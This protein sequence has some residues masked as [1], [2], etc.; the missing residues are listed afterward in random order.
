MSVAKDLIAQAAA[1]RS[2]WKLACRVVSTSNLTLSGLQAVDGVALAEDDRV[3][4]AGQTAG[5]LNGVYMVKPGAWVRAPEM[6]TSERVQLGSTMLVLEGSY[7]FTTWRLTSPTSGTVRLGVTAL[8]FEQARDDGE[9]LD[10]D[11][12]TAP[13]VH[14]GATGVYTTSSLSFN[15]SIDPSVALVADLV[16]DNGIVAASED[17]LPLCVLIHGYHQSGASIVASVRQRFASYGFA[18]LVIALRADK[19]DG[20]REVHDVDDAIAEAVAEHPT[21]AYAPDGSV[22]LEVGYSGGGGT[23]M[24]R[25][26]KRPDAANIRVAFFG[27]SDYGYDTTDSLWALRA[28]FQDELEVAVGDRT[29]V[30]YPYR[31][32]NAVEAIGKALMLAPV[33]K[34][35]APRLYLFWD[36]ADNSIP[37]S[38]RVRDAIVARGAENRLSYYQST[39]E[40]DVR[41]EHGYPDTVPDLIFAE[42][43]FVR[44][45]LTYDYWTV[46]PVGTCRVLGWMKTKRFEI[47]CGPNADPKNDEETGGK[48][49]VV[50]LEYDTT[51]GQ[52]IVTPRSGPKEE[53]G[54]FTPFFAS[55]THDSETA[56]KEIS[57]S[58]EWEF[59]DNVTVAELTK[60]SDLAGCTCELDSRVGITLA[61]AD[62]ATWADQS[63]NAANFAE[64]SN[65]PEA[66]TES[67]ETVVQF[68]TASSERLLLNDILFDAEEDFTIIHFSNGA[69]GV[70][71]IVFSQNNAA[72]TDGLVTSRLAFNFN[73][74]RI[75]DDAGAEDEGT[76]AGTTLDNWHVH[77]VR[78]TGNQLRK[79]TDSAAQTTE[80]IDTGAVTQTRCALG[81]IHGSPGPTSFASM[82]LG[83][84]ATFDR[85]LSD[86][87]LAAAIA[88]LQTERAALL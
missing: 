11:D 80:T 2:P 66:I 79:Q 43:Y 15:S 25:A 1:G 27:V 73:I 40:D 44:K 78:R 10:P 22:A 38:S 55:I 29:T 62:V 49:H 7:D 18:V 59:E 58:M 34:T 82:K 83:N 37:T 53:D 32:R 13:V 68:V 77:T 71:S 35:N 50:D 12:T 39:P 31:A 72:A 75:Y 20:A 23:V 63:G 28:D 48:D 30:L 19:D 70:D 14:A 67:G 74:G 69:S 87:E 21:I 76:G 3:L 26:C 42:R 33:S 24:A 41:Y 57:A 4:V 36:T 52:F 64:S 51:V 85:S 47:W 60:L 8:T 86:V 16:S 84:F 88:W 5:R 65:R 9:I 46:D 45:A 56:E 17:P 54:T 61:G 81:C 6:S